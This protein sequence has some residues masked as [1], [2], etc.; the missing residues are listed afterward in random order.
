M[1]QWLHCGIAQADAQSAAQGGMTTPANLSERHITAVHEAGHAAVYIRLRLGPF[2]HIALDADASRGHVRIPDGLQNPE[3]R[4]VMALA[5]C[6]AEAKFLN[7][8]L[9]YVLQKSDLLLA[10]L[11]L[12]KSPRRPRPTLAEA[13]RRARAL[14]SE[15]WSSI[16]AVAEALLAAPDGRLDY[17]QTCEVVRTH[18]ASKEWRSP[19]WDDEQRLVR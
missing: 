11:A 14:V 7:Q 9:L 3:D 8:R 19:R 10:A 6:V 12:M 13:L 17:A 1:A 4:A 15:E 2:D 5:G 18:E 16:Q